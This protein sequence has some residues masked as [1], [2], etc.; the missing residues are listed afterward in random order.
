MAERPC[1]VPNDILP[2]AISRFGRHGV[3]IDRLAPLDQVKGDV[4][5]WWRTSSTVATGTIDRPRFT[6][7]GIRPDLF[8]LSLGMSMALSPPLQGGQQL[9]FRTADRQHPPAQG[10]SLVIAT[11][12]RTGM[13]VRTETIEVIMATPAEGP[14]WVS[15]PRE[16]GRECPS[17]RTAAAGCQRRWRAT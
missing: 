4:N 8:S 11:S 2:V 6:L 9:L 14:S 1:S 17:S 7:S 5:A 15:R 13:P 3:D 12:R 10:I 16:R